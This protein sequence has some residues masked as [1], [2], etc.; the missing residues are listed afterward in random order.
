MSQGYR[1]SQL[2]KS[3]FIR[4]HSETVVWATLRPPVTSDTRESPEPR[5]SKP[6]RV[7]Q[8]TFGCAHLAKWGP[9]AQGR[10]MTADDQIRQRSGHLERQMWPVHS[11]QRMAGCREGLSEDLRHLIFTIEALPKNRRPANIRLKRSSR[12]CACAA[13]GGHHCGSGIKP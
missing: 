10:V 11:L 7:S 2:G 9:L 3:H 6:H 12:F 4:I 1:A 13:L 5:N 8:G